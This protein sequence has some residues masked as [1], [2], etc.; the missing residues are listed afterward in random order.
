M[1]FLECMVFNDS[2]PHEGIRA[3][4]GLN[5]KPVEGLYDERRFEQ[6]FDL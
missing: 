6:V 3:A 1:L 2:E 5:I 4:K